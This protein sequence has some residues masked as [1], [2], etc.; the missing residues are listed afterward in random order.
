MDTRPLQS[1]L[2]ET[3]LSASAQ[4]NGEGEGENATQRCRELRGSR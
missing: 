1:P 2:E 4:V 3:A